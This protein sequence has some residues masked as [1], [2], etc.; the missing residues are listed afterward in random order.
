MLLGTLVVSTLA[1][2]LAARGVIRTGKETMT[3]GGIF[4]I[5]PFFN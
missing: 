3:M 2:A 1:S 5:A 4:N